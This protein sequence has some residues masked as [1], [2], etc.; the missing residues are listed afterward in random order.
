MD[1]K[2]VGTAPLTDEEI[3]ATSRRLSALRRQL[4]T[5]ELS[6]EQYREQVRSVLERRTRA[7]P[8]YAPDRRR[9]GATAVHED[10]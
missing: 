4:D 1:V 7:V 9:S 5:G 3:V 8:G 2:Q 6:S 10:R